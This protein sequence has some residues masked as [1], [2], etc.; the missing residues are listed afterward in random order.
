MTSRNGKVFN[1]SFDP[2][3]DG[4]YPLFFAHSLSLVGA[5]SSIHTMFQPADL[6]SN[7]TLS[8]KPKV[9]AITPFKR[10]PQSRIGEGGPEVN[11]NNSIADD[12][13]IIISPST[14][15]V[16]REGALAQS[17]EHQLLESVRHTFVSTRSATVAGTSS[18]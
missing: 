16:D 2:Y 3:A 17:Q 12:P 15:R 13:L 4:H 11:G 8:D 5:I 14:S 9:S 6:Y 1:R 10:I 18:T 7:T